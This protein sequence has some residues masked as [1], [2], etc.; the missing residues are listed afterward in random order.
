[1]SNDYKTAEE[2]A[3]HLDK[4][5]DVMVF[6]Q[7][8]VF[9]PRVCFCC[10]SIML[11]IREHRSVFTLKRLA[12]CQHLFKLTDRTIHLSDNMSSIIPDDVI[13]YY[14]Y[15]VEGNYT[16]LQEC[17]ISPNTCYDEKKKGFLVCKTCFTP[18]KH[19]RYPA[20]G[21]KNGYM[22]GSAPETFNLLSAEELSCISLVRNT[23]HVFTY[24]GG[25]ATTIRGWHSMVEVDLTQ[26]QRTLR[27][28]DHTTLGFPDSIT[29]VL[30]G[31]MTDAQYKILR[32]KVNASRR[33][34]LHVLKWLI[35]NNCY[36]AEHF[37]SVPNIEDIPVP[38]IIEKVHIVDSIDANIELTEQMSMV[39]PDA[40]LDETTG[41]FQS[42][43][44]FKKVISE[45]NQGN[46]AVTLTTR[47][48]TYVYAQCE[49]NFVKAFPRQFP[50]G[51]GG[52][53]QLRFN[54]DE[55]VTKMDFT[56][57]IQ[58]VNNLSNLNFHTQLFSV[59]TWNI[60]EKRDMV[61][62]ACLRIKSSRQLQNKIAEADNDKF[63]D[64]VSCIES[65]VLQ[66]GTQNAERFFLDAVNSIT[67]ALPHS[68]EHARG[69]QKNAFS[70]QLRFGFP[71]VFFTVAPDDSS[72]YVVSVY[73]GLK[74]SQHDKLEDLTDND[75]VERANKRDQ[76]RI[77]Y[78][79]I[80][81]LW[82]GAVM[83]AIWKHVIGWDWE[84]SRGSPGLYGIP[85]AAMEST[86][87]QTR[88]RLHAHCLVWIQGGT[89]LLN[90]LHSSNTDKKLLAESTIIDIFDRSTST[91][92][93]DK[94]TLPNRIFT[95]EQPCTSTC[96]HARHK[97][98]C[99]QP[100]QLRE[101][102][103]QV[104]KK[105]HK[106]V[107]ATCECCK[108]E[109]TLQ[110]LVVACLAYWNSVMSSHEFGVDCWFSPCT[111][112]DVDEETVH[113]AGRKKLEE[114][115]FI[116]STPISDRYP[117]VSEVITN[118]VRNLHG[119][120]HN[121]QCFKKGEECRYKL[122][123]LPIIKTIIEEIDKFEDWY[124]YLGNKSTYDVYD[125]LAKRSEY[126]VFQNQACVAISLSK[127]GSNS[128]SQ[129]C[130]GGLKAIYM[131]KYPTKDTQKEDE[132]EYEKILHFCKRCLATRKF[133]EN[134]SEALSQAIGATLAHN[135]SNIVSAWLAKHLVNCRS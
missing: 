88:R 100:Q 1:M 120:N 130:S 60:L 46:T 103:H 84:C 33:N 124:D 133:E 10:D 31:P 37:Q 86:E 11:H 44:D 12:A 50:Y 34:M 39:F 25:V 54:S 53:N 94:K 107:I 18:L 32:K 64:Y 24:M 76:F 30:D 56:R 35:H 122:P 57:Y 29:V 109:Y 43:E 52:P 99:V 116:L 79:G 129:L 62:R 4:A 19:K 66:Q 47:A 63:A 6:Q 110:H 83:N 26:V 48:S 7:N 80:G 104:G 20:L 68:N 55:E 93:L 90:D 42:P 74:F 105:L 98:K 112:C 23:A 115:L 134:C 108:H 71:L 82:Y 126:D 135:S 49:S 36:Y 106:G 131:T 21:I 73:T 111:G 15:H 101:M 28:M 65:G 51:I 27:G 9:K 128:N 45:I 125:I 14:Q 87:E 58:H 16:W 61:N 119:H 77:K 92:L 113:V 70:M 72:S 95:H 118:A 2:C 123:A 78:A 17:V 121:T 13:S 8:G 127:L 59:L 75:I 132:S 40:T 67:F 117:E 97:P 114:L 89:E 81:A 96:G 69:N 102:R 5:L 22:I 85:I 41:G 38:Q 3:L 91:K